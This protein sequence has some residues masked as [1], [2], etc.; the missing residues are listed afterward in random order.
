MKRYEV[1]LLDWYGGEFKEFWFKS[2]ALKYAREHRSDWLWI[3]LNDNWRKTTKR[4]KNT[5]TSKYYRDEQGGYHK[6]LSAI[7][8]EEK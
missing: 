3:D 2:S 7:R 1:E 8:K 6:K 5:D 4:L